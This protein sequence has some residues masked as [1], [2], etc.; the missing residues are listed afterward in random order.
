MR[1][2]EP[3]GVMRCDV[4][5]IVGSSFLYNVDSTILNCAGPGRPV[6]LQFWVGAAAML[7][8]GKEKPFTLPQV[9][10][11]QPQWIYLALC[12]RWRQCRTKPKAALHSL[13]TMVG[14]WHI[15]LPTTILS[16][17][18]PPYLSS[19]GAEVML[20][21][22]REAGCR[23]HGWAHLCVPARFASRMAQECFMACLQPFQ[24]CTRVWSYKCYAALK[25]AI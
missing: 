18:H 17:L 14:I 12:Y 3:H 1:C 15:T 6:G 16:A 13:G 11:H 24:S 10:L 8:W 23:L 5:A 22:V 7:Q 19:A 20:Y 2:D 9:G 4:L 21:V 25:L